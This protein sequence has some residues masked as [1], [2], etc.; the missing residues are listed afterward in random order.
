MFNLGI[1]YRLSEGRKAY[2][3]FIALDVIDKVDKLKKKYR[4]EN[5]KAQLSVQKSPKLLACSDVIP[6][7]LAEQD[8]L[9]KQDEFKQV[10]YRA[11]HEKYAVDFLIYLYDKEFGNDRDLFDKTH[12]VRAIIKCVWNNIGVDAIRDIL[13]VCSSFY[14]IG[15]RNTPLYELITAYYVVPYA[16]FYFVYHYSLSLEAVI[17]R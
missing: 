13:T 11:R 7:S 4:E 14:Q 3:D 2:E 16:Q 15:G 9:L 1:K 8:F 17:K 10:Q 5:W 6:Y 12:E